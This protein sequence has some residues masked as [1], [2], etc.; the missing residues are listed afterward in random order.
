MVNVYIIYA[1]YPFTCNQYMSLYLKDKSLLNSMCLGLFIWSDNLCL[2]MAEFSLFRYNVIINVVRFKFIILLF[3]FY[4]CHLFIAIFNL[5][6]CIL[7]DYFLILY[8][9]L[10]YRFVSSISLFNFF[11]VVVLDCNTYP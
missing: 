9:Y 5:L 4:L 1:F 3:V 10:H 6:F 11:K 7:L 2:S 8:F